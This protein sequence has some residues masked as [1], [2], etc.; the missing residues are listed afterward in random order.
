[1]ED[2]EILDLNEYVLRRVHKN[3]VWPDGSLTRGAFTPN[4]N[5][6]DGISL[7]REQSNGGVT[8]SQLK[9]IPG[10]SSDDYIIV[11]LSVRDLNNLGIHVVT[12]NS[13]EGL[14]GHCIVPEFNY[15]SYKDRDQ[16]KAWWNKV[17]TT[18]CSLAEKVD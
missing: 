18:L 13:T 12:K 6:T 1:M 7:Y 4:P 14:P 17:Q 11:R 16:K 9:Q 8:P 2:G 3:Q 10:R 15:N 5:D